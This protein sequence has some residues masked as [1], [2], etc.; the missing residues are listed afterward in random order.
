MFSHAQHLLANGFVPFTAS[1]AYR[2]GKKLLY[3]ADGWARAS[4][5]NALEFCQD[6]HNALLMA[7][8][9]SNVLV[10]DADKPKPGEDAAD[11]LQRLTELIAQNGLPDG[12]PLQ[13]S[14]SGGLHLFFS[15]SKSTAA[16][17]EKVSNRTK[18]KVGGQATTIDVRGDGGCVLVSPT[19]YQTP[20]ESRCYHFENPLCH[21]DDLPPLPPWLLAILNEDSSAAPVLHCGSKR[22][23]N[24]AVVIADDFT[25]RVKQKIEVHLQDKMAATYPRQDGIDF[26]LEH[27]AKA[28][29]I[30]GGVHANNSYLCRKILDTCVWIKNYSKSCHMRVLDYNTHPV[31]SKIL[32]NPTVDDPFV[33][34]LQARMYAAGHQIRVSGNDHA[35]YC[36]DGNHWTTIVDITIQQELRLLGYEVISLLCRGLAAEISHSRGDNS[37]TQIASDLKQFEKARTYIQKASNIRSITDSAK[38][39]MWDENLSAKLDSNPDLLGVANG[40]ID[41]QQGLLRKGVPD[42]YVSTCLPSEYATCDTSDISTFI[43]SL[44]N[45]DATV[46]SFMQRLLGYA[47]TGHT[48]EQVWVIWTGSGS[49][50]KS[51]LIKLL[52]D[53]MGPLCVT[54]PREAVFDSGKRSSEGA[55]TPHLIPLIG[56]RLG[57]REEKA[58]TATL[59]EELIKQVTGESRI[60]ARGC[61]EKSYVSFT[62]THLPILVCNSRPPLDVDDQAMLRRII[63]VPFHNVYTTPSDPIRPYDPSNPTHRIKDPTLAAKLQT[64]EMQ[65]QLLA[66]LVEGAKQWYQHGL[67]E[68]PVLLHA[69]LQDYICENDKLSDFIRNSCTVGKELTVNAAEFRQAFISDSGTK[70]K[71]E[72]L[73]KAMQKRGYDYARIK[74]SGVTL[75][76]FTGLQL[77]QVPA[78]P[79][80][81]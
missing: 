57:I 2:N 70:V 77:D 29:T 44:F 40:V 36:F 75:R 31:L 38:Q 6:A 32:H 58:A 11:G 81:A 12:T 18:V 52:E 4:L 21:A 63:V 64:P 9:P 34:L 25:E 49:N 74:R 65:Q 67:G 69:E 62:A 33:A 27:R 45:H 59:N 19:A 10:I 47:I 55:P 60:T 24:S 41:L 22:K 71:Q 79:S 26:K 46:V 68:Q 14:G 73:K 61:H 42:D 50:G 15:L 30:C 39:L 78:V 35:F 1:L 51:L 53:L 3:P 72:D 54:M 13:R 8:G 66:W 48:R 20:P 28:C 56:K 37:K 16:G 23:I 5:D 76:V 7:T 80:C 43:G 17:L